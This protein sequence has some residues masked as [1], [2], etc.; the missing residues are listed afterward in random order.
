MKT[1]KPRIFYIGMVCTAAYAK[2][3]RD[4][5]YVGA[6]S[7]KMSSVVSALREAKARAVLVS[8]PF[9]GRSNG[10]QRG[11]VCRESGFPAIFLPVWR[12]PVARKIIGNLTLAWFSV[13]YVRKCD[14]VIFYNHAFEYLMALFVLRWRGIVV[15]QDI[16]DVPL[17]TDRG[18][19]ARLDRVGFALML[20]LASPRKITVSNEVGR[21]LRLRDYI[22]I[23]GVAIEMLSFA[24]HAKWA[25]L[26]AGGALRV[27]YGGTLTGATGLDL[28]CDA[29]KYLDATRVSV[30]REVEFLVTGVGDLVRVYELLSTMR[31]GRVR[32][33]VREGVARETYCELLDSCHAS[34]SLKNPGSE[35]SSTT[36]PS[37][38][39]EV[40]SRGLAL[41][42]T[43]VSDVGEIFTDDT[44]WLLPEFSY[45]ALSDI[46]LDM[47]QSPTEV[48]RR[49]EA[50]QAVARE[51]FA[52][53]TVGRALGDFLD[54]GPK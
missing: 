1:R 22:A 39:I 5:V 12:S 45:Q 10:W 28:F 42:S 34:L 27:H 47:A 25:A 41:V 8:L 33:E 53:R 32:V 49:A 13:R 17:V 16:E 11:C 15:F 6:A 2:A 21:L 14:R 46:L 50:G 30:D 20:R 35:I 54:K 18:V 7:G 24:S 26:R 48:R 51:R 37:K 9:V 19:R 52:P 38:V 44:A 23:Q 29:V 43:R 31:S 36:F 40:T 3:V 4:D